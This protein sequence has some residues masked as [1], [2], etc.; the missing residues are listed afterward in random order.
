MSPWK[1]VNSDGSVLGPLLFVAYI[2]DL[3]DCIGSS[4]VNFFAD[5]TKVYRE[6]CTKDE[7]ADFQKDLE[8]IFN[9]SKDWGMFFNVEKCK[10]MHVGYGNAVHF[11][12]ILIVGICKL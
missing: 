6:V 1:S 2:N 4:S 8:N 10:V 7:A 11:H 5:D 12:T 3:D 9:W